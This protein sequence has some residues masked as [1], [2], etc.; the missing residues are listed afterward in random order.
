MPEV[1]D[2]DLEVL[3]AQIDR[4]ITAVTTDQGKALSI[5]IAASFIAGT[6]STQVESIK[7]AQDDE[8]KGLPELHKQTIQKLSAEYFGYISEFDRNMGEQLKDRAREIVKEKAGRAELYEEISK[9]TEDIF[10]GSE[11]VVIDR[12][13]Q[14]RTTIEIGKDGRLKKAEKEIT[15]KY[16]TNTQAYSEMLA[17][18]ASHASYEDGRAAEYQEKGYRKWRF[19]GPVGE[20]SRPSHSAVVGNVYEYGTPESDMA[21]ALLHE[22]NCRHRSIVFWDD[23]DR[24]TDQALY[25]R[26][27]R[28]MG[29]QYDDEKEEWIFG[30]P[31]KAPKKYPNNHVDIPEI[32]SPEIQYT[33]AKTVKQAEKWLKENTDVKHVDF[34]GVKV[35]I[36]N[37]MNE[38]LAHHLNLAPKLGEQMGFYGTGQAQFT[39]YHDAKVKEFIEYWKKE[40]PNAKDLAEEMA[41]RQVTKKKMSAY[42]HS[43]DLKKYVFGGIAVNK[44]FGADPEMFAKSLQR[45]VSTAWHPVGCDTIKSVIDHEFGHALDNVYKVSDSSIVK[46][47]Y[48]KK[49]VTEIQESLSRYAAKNREEF[50]AE[51]WSEYL[52][53]PTPRPVSKEIGDFIISKINEEKT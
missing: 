41:R 45:D 32:E 21:Q 9:Y 13:G 23:P 10:R 19:I 51:A 17:R 40:Y 31:A 15:R 20:R 1:T 8:Y 28:K 46:E 24:D 27:K 37:E 50:V 12:R 11:S 2:A 36:V 44:K 3:D 22:P 49:S 30:D 16:V 43:W 34:K 26:E 38:R 47:L 53:N 18:T 29:L 35:D 52:N 33:P 39:L 7:S 5:H 42:A 48:N 4:M 25:D 6:K 14:K